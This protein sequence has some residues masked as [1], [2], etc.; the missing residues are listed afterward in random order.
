MNEHHSIMQIG[1]DLRRS[2]GPTPAESQVSDRV[3]LGLKTSKDG[4]LS[5][6]LFYSFSVLK[7]QGVFL[8]S[9]LDLSYFSLCPL[10]LILPPCTAMK[11][12]APSHR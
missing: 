1:R 6:N 8:T 12:L 5:G 4:D 10:P 9:S 2:P 11:R 7:L 3:R